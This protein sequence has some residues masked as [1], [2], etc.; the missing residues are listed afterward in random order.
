MFGKSFKIV[1]P[2]RFDIYMEEVIF[3]DGEAIIKIDCAAICKADIRYYLGNRDK[4]TLGLKYPMNLIHEAIGTVVL[5]KSNKF[6]VG[7]RVVLVP[8]IISKTREKCSH[9]VCDDPNL[10]ENYCPQAI[11]VSSNYN[12]FSR[13]YINYPV[14]NLIKIPD[15]IESSIATF[16][17]LISV[18]VSAYRRLDL[19]G[20]ETIGIWGDGILGYIFCSTFNQMHNGK[21][22]A[23]GKHEK[24]L[25][26]FPVHSYYQIGHKNINSE[27]ILVAYEC[28]GGN[29]SSLAIN[30]ILDNI[31]VGGKVILTGVAE[32]S[33]AINTRKILEKG[34]S[35]YGVT[36][37]KVTDF[38]KALVLLKNESFKQDIS[39]LILN[40]MQIR[41]I[42]D[43]YEAF[44]FE[45]YNK[46][47]GK[48]ILHFDL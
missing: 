33:I 23:V 24:K 1:E 13:E 28:V 18:A 38:E 44:E 9:C 25:R 35:I 41:N 45:R 29:A 12:G 36:R 20:N 32:D 5:D 48:N 14:D 30:E 31:L 10:G 42:V 37:S 15:E 34:L 16:S 4:K 46:E 19:S 43:Y 26:E 11:F 3:Y 27:D 40:E 6:K 2:K 8:N 21:I 22:I 7:D 39:K 47:L 17:E